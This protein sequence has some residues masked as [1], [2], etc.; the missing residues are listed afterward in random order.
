MQK[1][2]ISP[3]YLAG[4]TCMLYPFMQTNFWKTLENSDILHE[5]SRQETL[6][7]TCKIMEK[8]ARNMEHSHLAFMQIFDGRKNFV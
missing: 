1:V 5:S 8:I 2:N 4:K 7:V 6:H 3:V